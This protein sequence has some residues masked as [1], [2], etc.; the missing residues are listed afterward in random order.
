MF[1]YVKMEQFNSVL[2]KLFKELEAVH[3]IA[4]QLDIC[5]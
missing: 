4:A 3:S 2:N 1:R 5:Q